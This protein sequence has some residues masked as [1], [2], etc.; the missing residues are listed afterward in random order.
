[1]LISLLRQGSWPAEGFTRKMQP[2]GL[3]EVSASPGR[4]ITTPSKVFSTTRVLDSVLS[5]VPWISAGVGIC[6]RTGLD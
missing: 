6:I 1:M 5:A 4:Q 2:M 3:V